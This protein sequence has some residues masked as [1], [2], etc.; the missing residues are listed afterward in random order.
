M[1]GFCEG[2]MKSNPCSCRGRTLLVSHISSFVNSAGGLEQSWELRKNEQESRRISIP[3]APLA[4]GV[5]W[6]RLPI[7]KGGNPFNSK[8]SWYHVTGRT[9]GIS[10]TI[11]RL[12]LHLPRR[13]GASSVPGRGAGASLPRLVAKTPEHKQQRRYVTNSTRAKNVKINIMEKHGELCE[14]QSIFPKI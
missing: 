3:G 7:C 10:L 4:Q 14:E 2:R 1:R 6:S 8:N 13:G 9:S 5:N 12:G 11:Q